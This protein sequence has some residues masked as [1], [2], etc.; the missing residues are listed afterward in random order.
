VEGQ[1]AL[2]QEFAPGDLFGAIG[3]GDVDAYP[4]EVVALEPCRAA[5]FPM[6]EFQHLIEADGLVGLAVSRMLLRQLRASHQRLAERITLSAAGRVHAAL[7]RLAGSRQRI[8]PWPSPTALAPEVQS[9]RETVSRTLN[10]LERRG[11]IRREGAALVV[12]SSRR[13]ADLVV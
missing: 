7:L 11:I 1:Q 3:S 9:T 4:V 5:V 10:A 12:V 8:E 13:L 6:R 2:M